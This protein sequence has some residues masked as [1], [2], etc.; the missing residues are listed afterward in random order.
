MGFNP[1]Q[2]SGLERRWFA[3]DRYPNRALFW[4]LPRKQA[5]CPEQFLAASQARGICLSASRPLEPGRGLLL[6]LAGPTPGCTTTVL[7]RV[8]SVAPHPDGSWLL[9]CDLASLPYREEAAR[10]VA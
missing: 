3:R 10:T 5:G 4:S 2:L 1:S 8:A 9:R 6:Q 7:A